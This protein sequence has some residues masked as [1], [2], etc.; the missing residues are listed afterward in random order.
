MAKYYL[1]LDQGTTGIT[2]ILFDENWHQISRGYQELQQIYPQSGWVEHDPIDIWESACFAVTQALKNANASP[3]DILC[4]GI[5]HEGESVMLWDKVTGQPI[6]NTIVW[7]DRRTSAEAEILKANHGDFIRT[8]TGLNVDSYFSALK[9]KWLLHNV[10]EAGQLLSQ[11]RLLCG[12]MDTWLIWKMTGGAVHATDTSTSSRTMLM[13]LQSGNWDDEV[14]A[15]LEIPRTILPTIC[16]SAGDYGHC[17]PE[18]FCNISAS[19][20]GVLVDQQAALFGQTCFTPGTVKT[21]YGTGCF[22]QMNTGDKVIDSSNGLL[23]LVCWNMNGKTTYGLDGGIYISGAA[24][25][26]LRD[27]LKIISS[28]SETETMAY[29]AGSNNGVYFVPAFTGLAAPYWDSYA[30]GTLI[31]ITGGTTREQIVRATLEST[32]YQVYDVLHAMEKDSGIVLPAMR[33]DGG[34]VVNNFLMQFQA[35]ILNIP[36]LI[37]EITEATALGSAFMASIG[38]GFVSSTEELQSHWKLARSF[39]PKMSNDERMHLLSQWH[40]AV[41]RAR[42]WAED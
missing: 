12:T 16:P 13:N 18:L 3:E 21:T 20:S 38:A 23:P 6:Y 10:P 32:A 33:C 5:D 41:E 29:T 24:T 8:R 14:L 40:R 2:A 17:V 31:G 27:G 19:I 39:E 7:Q 11:G 4:V 37:P 22:M 36:V 25:Q 30:R 15:L 42:N 9:I 35:D 1:G 34:A 26:W 28:A